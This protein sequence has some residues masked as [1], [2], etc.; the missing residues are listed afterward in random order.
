MIEYCS[1]G[2]P[3]FGLDHS[4]LDDEWQHVSIAPIESKDIY[5]YKEPE[6]QPEFEIEEEES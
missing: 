6:G 4:H 5:G 2:L 3:L 1:C